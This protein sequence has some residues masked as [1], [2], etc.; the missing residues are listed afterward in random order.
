MP[1]HLRAS[2]RSSV[3][4]V[5]SLCHK[6]LSN[7]QR[8][9][10]VCLHLPM[11]KSNSTTTKFKFLSQVQL[12]T[13]RWW[14]FIGILFLRI[15]TGFHLWCYAF[16][17]PVQ[18]KSWSPDCLTVQKFIWLLGLL[19]AFSL[20]KECGHYGK[21]DTLC[22]GLNLTRWQG[23]LCSKAKL[24]GF[25]MIWMQMSPSSSILSHTVSRKCSQFQE[26]VCEATWRRLV[27]I[28]F[29]SHS[30]QSWIIFH[31]CYLQSKPVKFEPA[32]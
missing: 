15:Y 17:L 6:S 28:S 26:A 8:K 22:Q 27:G 13:A 11:M 23:L 5:W 2:T 32:I 24:A 18:S 4:R 9:V 31:S 1:L 21:G 14:N 30:F 19:S 7:S 16:L 20:N 25:R 29:M 3:R 12:V 10:P